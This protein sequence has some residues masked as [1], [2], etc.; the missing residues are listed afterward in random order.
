MVNVLLSAKEQ[1]GH[2]RSD[3]HNDT[4]HHLIHGSSTLCQRDKH[5]RRSAK[6]KAGGNRKQQWVN[7]S[8]ELGLLSHLCAGRQWNDLLLNLRVLADH[9]HDEVGE[10]AHQLTDEHVGALE[11]RMC[12]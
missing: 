10:E 9:L 6:V 7:I 1:H 2:S 12:E 5:K 4:S 8:L 11:I 3:D